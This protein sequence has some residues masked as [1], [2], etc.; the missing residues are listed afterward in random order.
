MPVV[1]VVAVWGPLL[2][3][4]NVMVR[5]DYLAVVCCI[6]KRSAR[7]PALSLH[8]LCL[9]CAMLGISLSAK[10]IL[11]SENVSA[12]ALSRNNL[13]LFFLQNPFASPEPTPL[14]PPLLKLVLDQQL[15][16]ASRR[17]MDLSLGIC[18][19]P[20]TRSCLPI[21]TAAL[22]FPLWRVRFSFPTV[23][24]R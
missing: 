22:H 12:D 1:L 15:T 17:W 23:T 3:H 19:A 9:L 24:G 16:V 8:L 11:G 21:C 13:P 20:S 7:D 14:P 18:I 10:H 2:S 5:S 4:K 6:N